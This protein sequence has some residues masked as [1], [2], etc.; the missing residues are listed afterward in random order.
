[1]RS[2]GHRSLGWRHASDTRHPKLACG[3]CVARTRKCRDHDRARRRPAA[4]H[5]VRHTLSPLSHLRPTSTCLTIATLVSRRP[6]QPASPSASRLRRRRRQPPAAVAAP[7][8]D[9]HLRPAQLEAQAEGALQAG[10][11]NIYGIP[12]SEW[13]RLQSPA[14]Y[15]GNEFGAVRKPWDQAEIRFALTYP[16]IYEGAR[17][18]T[19]PP[20]PWWH[21]VAAALRRRRTPPPPDAATCV[22]W[23]PPTWATSSCTAC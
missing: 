9:L 5:E 15:L 2:E 10:T 1:M 7:T 3:L 13:V 8:D 21:P 20:A 19:V 16:E 11:G 14:R 12:R 6:V 23:A 4:G 17:H 18:A 22:Q